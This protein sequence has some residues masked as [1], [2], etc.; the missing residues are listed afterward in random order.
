H[1]GQRGDGLAA[2]RLAHET[3]VLA[4]VDV[5]GDLVHGP[6]GLLTAQPEGDAQVAHRQQ[7][8]ALAGL[9]GTHRRLLG[10]SA[11]RM[12]SPKRVKPRA[13]TAMAMP[14]SSAS[15][16]AMAKR[17][18]AA[19]SIRPHSATAG[20]GCPRPRNESAAT[21]MMAVARFR[22]AWT[23]VGAIEFGAMCPIT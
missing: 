14:G 11:S 6:G 16:G 5:E 12:A 13:V 22:V 4:G 19:T 23:I 8:F 20:S 10:S 17:S 3:D 9:G 1:H 18:W 7:W 21:S 15:W 2:A